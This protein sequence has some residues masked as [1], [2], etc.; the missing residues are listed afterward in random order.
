MATDSRK[1]LWKNVQALMA[2]QFGKENVNG[3]ATYVG[4]GVGSVLRLRAQETSV[5]VEIIDKIAKRF[6]LEPWQLLV[7]NLVANNPPALVADSERMKK[8][9]ANV[10]KSVQAMSGAIEQDGNTGSGDL[11]DGY[12]L[13]APISDMPARVLPGRKRQAK[14]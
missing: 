11:D 10:Q 2:H 8:L 7:P 1:I 5:G 6:D 3:F 4:I 9:L 13:P 14:K 12:S